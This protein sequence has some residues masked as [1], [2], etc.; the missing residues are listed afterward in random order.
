MGFC[1]CVKHLLLLSAPEGSLSSKP[2]KPGQ[3]SADERRDPP[4]TGLLW[5]DASPDKKTEEIMI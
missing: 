4:I 3:D 2:W 5:R 1:V